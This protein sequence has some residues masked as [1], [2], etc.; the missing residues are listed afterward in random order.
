MFFT[1]I[2]PAKEDPE[3]I[4]N[5]IRLNARRKIF[6]YPM[7]ASEKI[8]DNYIKKQY[9]TNLKLLCLYVALKAKYNTNMNGEVVVTFIEKKWD[10]IA[11]LI[12]YGTGK[13]P[14]SNILKFALTA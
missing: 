1:S 5:K 2:I 12:T 6:L 10:E 13:I 3:I 4:V 14:G 9:K 8:L 11:S 7:H